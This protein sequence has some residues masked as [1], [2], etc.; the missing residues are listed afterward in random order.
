[1]DGCRGGRRCT[2]GIL[3][4]AR[5]GCAYFTASIAVQAAAGWRAR[6]RGLPGKLSCPPSSDSM[7]LPRAVHASA[8]AFA[9]P[10]LLR[11][12]PSRGSAQLCVQAPPVFAACAADQGHSAAG[13]N[14]RTE[15]GQCSSYLVWWMQER[16]SRRR[17]RL[18]CW[19]RMHCLRLAPPA[20][21]CFTHAAS[22][23]QRPAYDLEATSTLFTPTHPPTRPST[24]FVMLGVL[25]DHVDGAPG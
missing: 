21:S 5:L 9:V 16:C 24:H 22:S 8:A 20:V 7:H 25:C 11:Q 4:P 13:H 17:R 10:L 14:P 2:G 1:M 12:C 19:R 6:P 15:P 18:V 23:L 3:R